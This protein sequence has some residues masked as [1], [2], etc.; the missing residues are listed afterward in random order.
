MARCK[1]ISHFQRRE[2]LGGYYIARDQEVPQIQGLKIGPL[3]A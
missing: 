1:H 2:P 3:E